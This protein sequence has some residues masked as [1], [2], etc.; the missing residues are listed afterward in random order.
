MG[1]NSLPNV[2]KEIIRGVKEVEQEMC[3][4]SFCTLLN[5]VTDLL[6]LTT[7]EIILRSFLHLSLFGVSA[8]ELIQPTIS[9]ARTCLGRDEWIT[10][11]FVRS[12]VAKSASLMMM[13]V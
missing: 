7:C 5:M 9:P 8:V 6:L 11:R 10:A 13:I 2:I 12:S 4:L 3:R 1:L